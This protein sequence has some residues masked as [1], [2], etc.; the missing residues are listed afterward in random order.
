MDIIKKLKD[1]T[2]CLLQASESRGYR[3]TKERPSEEQ[4]AL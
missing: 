3:P 1:K 4:L 2:Y